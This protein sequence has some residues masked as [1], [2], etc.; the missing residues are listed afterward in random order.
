MPKTPSTKLFDLIKSLSGSEKR[1]FKI[2]AKS[3]NGDQ[4]NKYIQLFD[5][6]EAQKV[7]DDEALRAYIYK[8]QKIQSR[9]YSELKAYLYDLILHSLHSYD[10]KSNV[11][12]RLRSFLQSIRVLYKRG[13]YDDC[14]ELITKSQKLAEI[15]ERFE[16]LFDLIQWKK[17]IAYTTADLNLLSKQLSNYE[18]L[19]NNYLDQQK[20]SAAY[21]NIF[22]RIMLRI[23]KD[24]LLRS[25]EK[26]AKLQSI[27][28]HPLLKDYSKATCHQSRVLYHRIW[29][30]Y[31][32]G[33]VDY[34]KLYTS[35]EELIELMESRPKLLKEDVSEYISATSNFAACCGLLKKYDEV[36]QCL[37]KFKTIS[38]N[39]LDDEVRIHT[40]YYS[41]QFALF[42]FTGE[43]DKAK[44]ALA[45]HLRISK[46]YD[47]KTFERGRF[48]F[49]YFYIYFGTADY[50]KALDYLND[51][52]NLPRSVE[53]QDLQSL[54]RILNLIIHFEMNN[55]ILLDNLFRSTYRFLKNR[56][57]V[58]DFEKRMLD[59]I[60]EV[61][62]LTSKKEIKAAFIRLKTDFENYSKEPS[63]RVM[64]QY[65][66]FISWV[67]SKIDGRDFA[68]VVRQKYKTEKS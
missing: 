8:G 48:L 21:Q 43:F 60:R 6:I 23:R 50:D 53:R 11:H 1:Y 39:T 32:F 37:D 65:F 35:C 44:K 54:S 22:Y 61:N 19:E 3:G 46:K 57:R 28:D 24:S 56:N 41:K 17:K 47:E 36:Q 67:D 13:H 26:K 30:L 18:K 40:E 51:W 16:Y 20:N 29:G 64:F 58:F 7:Y 59:F 2:Q 63:Q 33:T 14:E 9:K 25:D 52:L 27:V 42:I 15:Y 49:Q 38:P 66:D 45:D 10:E 62:T 31:Y 4:D 34:K 12:F 68:E 55:S 5:A